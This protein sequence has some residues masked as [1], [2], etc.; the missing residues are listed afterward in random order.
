LLFAGGRLIVVPCRTGKNSP[1]SPAAL[2]TVEDIEKYARYALSACSNAVGNLVNPEK[3]VRILRTCVVQALDAQ[4]DYYETLPSY[5]KEWVRELQHKTIDST[6]GLMPMWT[7]GEE[8]RPGLVRTV[9]DHIRQR[10]K[11]A[12]THPVA[13]PQH[14]AQK[15]EEQ[16]DA[17]RDECRLTVE[18][19]AAR[20]RSELL[21]MPRGE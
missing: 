7:S 6:L 5:R 14:K 17:F 8:F 2:D 21:T 16:L 12:R 15:I 18:D 20:G 4:I 1:L 13:A 9:R 10:S 19:L 11:A 3:A